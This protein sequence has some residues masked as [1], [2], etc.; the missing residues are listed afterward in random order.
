MPAPPFIDYVMC[1]D[2]STAIGDNCG[3]DVPL[4]QQEEIALANIKSDPVF[5]AAIEA[6]ESYPPKMIKE[7]PQ[8]VPQPETVLGNGLTNGQKWAWVIGL[9]LAAWGL[10]YLSEKQ[11]NK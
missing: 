6:G 11:A 10:I 7:E 9:T 5:M 3:S 4:Y 1:P 8:V 2:G